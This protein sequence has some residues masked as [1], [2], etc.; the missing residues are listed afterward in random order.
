MNS[1]SGYLSSFSHAFVKVCLI[2][3]LSVFLF[4]PYGK[5][6]A[7]TVGV[8]LAITTAATDQDKPAIASDG[9][10]YLVV[11]QSGTSGTGTGIDIYG[12]F[13]NSSGGAVN[14]PFV[15]SNAAGDQTMPS[16]AYSS[17]GATYKFMVAYQNSTGLNDVY[18]AYVNLVGS[19][20][21]VTAVGTGGV[22]VAGTTR[23]EEAPSVASD[24]TNFFVAY[25]RSGTQVR[26]VSVPGGGGAVTAYTITTWTV[27]ATGCTAPCGLPSISFS[28]GAGNYFVSYESY[29]T[30]TA[31]GDIM[32]ATITTGGTAAAPITIANTAAT[33]NRYPSVAF[34]NLAGSTGWLVSWQDARNGAANNDI[35]GQLITT[36]GVLNGANFPISTAANDQKNPR[37]VHDGI[38]FFAAW[39]DMRSGAAYGEIYGT[40]IS[41]AGA[42]LSTAGYPIASGTLNN[43]QNPAIGALGSGFLTAWGQGTIPTTFDLYGQLA[44]QPGITGLSL[45]S[46]YVG[47]TITA[48][49]NNFGVT[50]DTFNFGGTAAST[51][52]WANTS[53]NFTV[54]NGKIAGNYSA[55]ATVGGWNSNSQTF[56]VL[57][58]PP[59]ANAGTP[60]SV[61]ENT[62]VTLN[63][64]ASTD[65]NGDSISYIWTQIGGTAVTLSSSTAVM[66][67]FTAPAVT[68]ATILT[69]Q[70]IVNDGTINSTASTVTVTVNNVN[71]PP[72]LNTIGAKSVNEGGNLNFTISGSDPDGDPITYSAT[73]LPSGATFNTSTQVFDW[74][75]TY[76]QSGSYNVTF[77]VSDG[78]LSASEV[79]TITVNNVNRAPVLN[80]IGAKNVNEAAN[81]NF[82]ISG[83]DPDGD[84]VTYSAAGLPTGATFNTSTRVFDWTPTYTQSGSYN[85]TFTVSDGSLNG[86]EVVTI[87]VN[88]VN[89]SPVL[90]AIGAK[91]INEGSN[92][93]FTVSGS[94]PDADPLT[95]SAT[96][97]PTGATFNTSTRVFD[98]TP[99]YSQSGSYNVTFTVSDG[100]LSASEVVTITVNN[101]NQAPVLNAI[102]A[103]AVNENVNLN[104]TISGSD[105]DGDAVTYSA[106][107]VPTG[108]TFNT[109]TR[110]FD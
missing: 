77:T 10:N 89:R 80:V 60:Q 32:G 98:W 56:T 46:G 62:L 84:A 39:Q 31:N 37:V 25:V 100:S 35:Y 67:T 76:S 30:D 93:N 52:S 90:N 41:S 54:P 82:T 85:V 50:T 6:N 27:H 63:G 79:V 45:T 33:L 95:Y 109:S 66:P 9:T 12:I 7:A 86:S 104:F 2:L 11:Y 70:L 53:I 61:N 99:T 55:S 92:L 5:A 101:V 4:L 8:P 1:I 36:A 78:L 73:G 69:F 106:T 64:S 19:T 81:L 57:N 20:A 13:L 72:V 23:R 105:P 108:A 96:G 26:V 49:G 102:G 68:T 48:T 91:G 44:N 28:S 38:N 14:V 24:G 59:T 58:S 34:S 17:T 65:P 18:G 3:C 21:T 110:V 97:L 71:Q 88:N 15:I 94:D 22:I 83:S 40:G 47:N 43:K 42:I 107:G 75:P 51:T 74:T 103:K 87:T 29:I 16:V